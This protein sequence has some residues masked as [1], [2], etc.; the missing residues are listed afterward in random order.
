LFDVSMS[1]LRTSPRTFDV[2]C[3]I[4][5]SELVL[6]LFHTNLVG[7]WHLYT[8]RLATDFGGLA[9]FG[10]QV[11]SKLFTIALEAGVRVLVCRR[12]IRGF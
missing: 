4:S 12:D 8:Q 1:R 10:G 11:L 5:S 3:W 7:A 6:Q 9:S 2:D